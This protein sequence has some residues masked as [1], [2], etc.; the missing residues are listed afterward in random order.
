MCFVSTHLRSCKAGLGIRRNPL[1][2]QRLR[3][4]CRRCTSS[5]CAN[6]GNGRG[7]S[8]YATHTSPRRFRN[9][10]RKIPQN[11]CTRNLGAQ[12]GESEAYMRSLDRRRNEIARRHFEALL[13]YAVCLG[14]NS[15]LPFIWSTHEALLRQGP[16]R[17]SFKSTSHLLPMNP[18]RN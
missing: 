9:Y 11:S 7:R 3:I 12:Q 17:H 13:K 4:P 6:S 15:C 5:P 14:V 8:S 2:S 1:D 10:G 16:D 18:A